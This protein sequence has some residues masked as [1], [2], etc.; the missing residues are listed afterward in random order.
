MCRFYGWTAHYVENMEASMAEEYYLASDKIEAMER[1]NETKVADMP[2]LKSD[3]RR[4]THRDLEKRI[5]TEE[6]CMD[7]DVFWDKVNG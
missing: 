4:K 2:H 6:D 5:R 3:A 7:F 1:I